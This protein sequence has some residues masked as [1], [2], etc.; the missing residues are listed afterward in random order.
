MIDALNKNMPFDQFTIQQ[1]AGDLMPEVSLDQQIATGFNRNTLVNREGGTDPE[2]DRVKRTIDRINTVGN[3]WLGLT[4]ECAQCHSHKYDPLRQKEYYELFAFFNSLS[5]PNIGAPLVEARSKYEVVKTKFDAEHLPF[6]TAVE[7]Y[8]QDELDSA[9]QQWEKSGDFSD[10]AWTVL[11][12]ESIQS[13]KG[14]TLEL[15][16]DGSI[17]AS[18]THPGRQE[19]YTLVFDTDRTEITG[20]RIEALTDDRLP[21]NG[22][23]R[24]PLGNFYVTRFDVD[25]TPI[26][27]SINDFTDDSVDDSAEPTRITLTDPK[28]TFAEPLNEIAHAISPHPTNGWS[29]L[30]KMGQ[31]HEAT[32]K[33]KEPF[34]FKGGTRIK[35]AIWQ[36]SVGKHFYSLGRFRISLTTQKTVEKKPLPLGGM[37]DL[38]ATTIK[39]DL[40]VRSPLMQRELRSYF[41]TVDPKRVELQKAADEHN[42]KAPASPYHVTKAQVIQ[43]LKEPR[44]TRFLVRGDFLA[45]DYEVSA[46]TPAVFPALQPRGETPDRLDLARWLV[47]ARNPLTARVT[48]NRIWDRYFGRGIVSTLKDFGTQGAPPTHPELL[49]WLATSFREN[50]WDMKALHKLIVSSSTYRQSSHSRPDLNERDPLNEWLSHQNRLRVEGEIVRDAALSVSGLMKHHVG[51]PSVRPPQP[52][53]IAGL[54]YAGQVKWETSKGDDRYR[55]GLYTFFQRTVPYPM[56]ITFDSPDSNV[57]CVRRNRSNTPLQALTLWNDPVFHECSQALGKRIVH[58]QTAMGIHADEGPHNL[59]DRRIDQAFQTCFGRNPSEDD[60]EAIAE[61]F[62]MQAQVLK[63]DIAAAKA[64][65]GDDS[66]ADQHA[67][68]LAVWTTI[69]RTLLNLDEFVTRE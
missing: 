5:E 10:P 34:G 41:Q 17:Y 57:S 15:L 60:R 54:G 58:E 3:V 62:E 49:D 28:A 53:A 51:G 42:Q 6:Q 66:L 39:T 46:G 27:D 30:P 48:V 20:F 21:G 61:L 26:D 52:E 63:Q 24:G 23:G 25:V 40:S 8:D 50:G 19:V 9:M 13:K 38:L 2:E 65:A 35:I 37:T 11:R 69:G 31:S 36:S 68:E 29:I 44:K 32:F 18:G 47:D 22:P 12:P 4:V 1:L 45:P 55:R 67:V 59:V 56:L 43:E 7:Q 33:V 64:I 14:S 16:E